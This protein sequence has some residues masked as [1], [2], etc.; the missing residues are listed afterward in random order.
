MTVFDRLV[1]T[2]P[3][4]SN[5][6]FRRLW[7]GTSASSFGGQMTTVAVLFQVWELTGSPLWVGAIGVANAVPLIVFGLLGGSLAD[8]VD[9]RRLVLV[10]TIGSIAGSVLLATQ[11][12]L[13]MDSL[14]LVLGLVAIS[15]S[16]A[17]LGSPARRTFVPRLLPKNQVAAGIALT[18]LG[19]QASMLIGPALA[20]LVIATWG[21]PVC[22]L[23]D[24]ASY[25]LA[26]YGVARLPA[27]P[28]F[29]AVKSAGLKAITAGW[30]YIARR[31]VLRGSFLSD[32]AATA[33]AMPVALFPMINDER[34]GGRPQTL[35]LF[36]SA[37]AIGGVVAGLL[38]GIITHA[39]RL[40]ALQL[41][42]AALWGVALIGFGLAGSWWLSLLC[43]AIAGAAD[44]VAVISRGTVVQ[45]D[46][47]DSFRGRVS[48]VEQ[49]VGVAGPELGN[50]RAG[51]LASL[52]SAGGAVVA[53]GLLCVA[54]VAAV[55]ATHATL[56]RFVISSEPAEPVG[57][58]QVSG[59]IHQP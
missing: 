31:P 15:A 17:A 36:L 49:I 50:V 8:V 3:L 1:D 23:L 24:A 19:F 26:L 39:R 41:G 42:A 43:L 33:L 6:A 16:F 35:G 11:A 46:T 30:H 48:S 12:V 44:T 29:G 32:L 20:G 25:L 27:M 34:F 37:I 40:G 52:T 47:D 55:A 51:A 21:L 2:G 13:G 45:L 54:G 56:R 58:Q 5:P 7:I 57:Q 9:R 14:P 4:R 28:V 18:H 22:Y 59:G 53:G 38:S 10:T